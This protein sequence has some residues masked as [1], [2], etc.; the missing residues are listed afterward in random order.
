M[1][2]KQ[3]ENRS[4]LKGSD[5]GKEWHS[6]ENTGMMQNGGGEEQIDGMSRQGFSGAKFDF[7]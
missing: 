1:G 3:K 5:C 6:R 4:D 2:E 7:I